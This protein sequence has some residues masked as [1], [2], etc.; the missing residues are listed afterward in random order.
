MVLLLSSGRGWGEEMEEREG[1]EKQNGR[2]EKK[3]EV[4]GIYREGGKKKKVE[5]LRRRME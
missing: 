5:R 3:G 4:G 2:T 1:W